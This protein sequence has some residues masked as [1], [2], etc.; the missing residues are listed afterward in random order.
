MSRTYRRR[1]ERHDYDWVLRDSCWANGTLVTFVI[2]PRSK[3]GRCAIARFHSDACWTLRSTAPRW[4]R[5][6]FDHQLR[7]LNQRQLRRSL[8]NPHYEPVFAARHR[9]NANWSWW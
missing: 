1:G 3:E 8:D 5:R 2:D 9:H 6:F 7:T 4:Y